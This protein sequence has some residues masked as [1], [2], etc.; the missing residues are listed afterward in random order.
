MKRDAENDFP[1]FN[2]RHGS[3]WLRSINFATFDYCFL[4]SIFG[5]YS[6]SLTV[7]ACLDNPTPFLDAMQKAHKWT[8]A[9]DYED[10]DKV[11]A[12]MKAC[13][14]FEKSLIRYKLLTPSG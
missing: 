12:D 6:L 5:V 13:N 2:I 9:F 10:I 3:K 4:Y 14:V 7:C 8:A 1:L 11:I